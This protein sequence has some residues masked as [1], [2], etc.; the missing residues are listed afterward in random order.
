[1]SYLR[2]TTNLDWL[3]EH[4]DVGLRADPAKPNLLT[5]EAKITHISPYLGTEITGVQ[6]SQLSK[7]GLDELALYASQRKVL[8][9]RDQDFKDLTPERQIEI[10]R[11]VRTFN[12]RLIFVDVRDLGTLDPSSVTQLQATPLAT[13]NFT[14]STEMPRMTPS[15]TTSVLTALITP[16]GTPIFRMNASLQGLRSSSSSNSPRL[17]ATRCSHRRSRLIIACQT[18]LRRGWR[19]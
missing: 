6:I 19:G 2:T 12:L 11:Y 16:P 13:P 3:V 10:A 5:P 8:L 4:V 14:L 15:S 17:E 9:F 18:S 7:E 1:M